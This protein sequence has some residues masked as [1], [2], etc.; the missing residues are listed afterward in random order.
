[1]GTIHHC[2]LGPCGVE[3]PKCWKMGAQFPCQGVCWTRLWRQLIFWGKTS[4]S[5]KDG[6]AFSDNVIG[7]TMSDRVS[8]VQGLVND[9]KSS[10]SRMKGSLGDG[11]IV[12]K[13]RWGV[14]NGED[15]ALT[16]V[17]FLVSIRCCLSRSTNNLCCNRK[18]ALI[19]GCVTLATRNRQVNGVGD[20]NRGLTVENHKCWW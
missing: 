18:S 4:R 15:F 6:S 20:R 9:R 1:M 3:R 2:L 17:P 11:G 13:F 14:E 19:I 10:R 12:R 7:D 16:R 8:L 5:C